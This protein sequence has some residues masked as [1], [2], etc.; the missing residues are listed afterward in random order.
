MRASPGTYF[1]FGTKIGH[2]G[3]GRSSGHQS[4][5]WPARSVLEQECTSIMYLFSR[6]ISIA[7]SLLGLSLFCSRR[8]HANRPCSLSRCYLAHAIPMVVSLRPTCIGKITEGQFAGG[9][10]WVSGIFE[11]MA[12]W[13]HENDFEMQVIRFEW[14][15]SNHILC[16]ANQKRALFASYIP[17]HLVDRCCGWVHG[18]VVVI[19]KSSCI[20][21][22]FSLVGRR[23]QTF[24][25]KFSRFQFWYILFFTIHSAIQIGPRSIASSTRSIISGRPSVQSSTSIAMILDI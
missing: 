11:G 16:E 6:H 22:G 25:G 18:W 3:F 12:D 20:C 8:R 1:V 19:L 2:H 13:M 5:I 7:W 21:D 17:S 4:S 14:H 23:Q 15:A 24:S 9:E 10:L